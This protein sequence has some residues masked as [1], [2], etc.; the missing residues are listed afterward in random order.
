MNREVMEH[1]SIE[2][3]RQ[4]LHIGQLKIGWKCRKVSAFI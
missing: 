3:H 1:V 4:A 2:C